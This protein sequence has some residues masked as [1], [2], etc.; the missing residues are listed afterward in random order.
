MIRTHTLDI[1]RICGRCYRRSAVQVPLDVE[2]HDH[3][4]RND[5]TL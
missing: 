5:M 4:L 3:T 1:H 2:I